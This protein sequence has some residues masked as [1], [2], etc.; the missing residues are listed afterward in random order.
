[1]KIDILSRDRLFFERLS[2]RLIR[3]KEL[4][5][6]LFD[7]PASITGPAT[8]LIADVSER[9]GFEPDGLPL[10]AD[11]YLCDTREDTAAESKYFAKYSPVP[12]LERV[13][14]SLLKQR[15]NAE[16]INPGSCRI[17]LFSSPAG[18]GGASVIAAAAAMAAV[19]ELGAEEKRSFFLSLEAV[20]AEALFQAEEGPGLESVLFALNSRENRG[21]ER[22]LSMLATSRSGVDFIRPPANIADVSSVSPDNLNSILGVL[23]E[24]GRYSYIAVDC[25]FSFGPLF[26]TAEN[27]SDELFLIENEEKTSK[28]KLEKAMK[29]LTRNC[30]IIK[31]RCRQNMPENTENVIS[32]PDFPGLETYDVV[33]Q[34]AA[35][36][37][38]SAA[39]KKQ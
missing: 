33:R 18:G 36:L 35:V 2:L 11:L 23:R 39:V 25:P 7:D 34:I 17:V 4:E 10:E 28:I 20:Q 30:G 6:R 37:K 22:I 12:V 27:A 3:N 14:L 24:C 32:I 38:D 13:L 15:K 5:I 29:N 26:I 8:A 31:N 16:A 19:R 1:M 21:A 9:G